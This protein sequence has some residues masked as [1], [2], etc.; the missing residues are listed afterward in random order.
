MMLKE[1]VYDISDDDCLN[2]KRKSFKNEKKLRFVT[3]IKCHIRRIAVQV[4]KFFFDCTNYH[5]CN[6]VKC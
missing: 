2:Q 5:L 3:K 6:K 1:Y 4:N